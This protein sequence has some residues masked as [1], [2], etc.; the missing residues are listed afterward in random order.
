MKKDYASPL[1]EVT[2]VDLGMAILQ[3]PSMPL[4]P[5]PPGAPERKEPAF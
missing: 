5:A 2:Q 3:D 1:M 4:L